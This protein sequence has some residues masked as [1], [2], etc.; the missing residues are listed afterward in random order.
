MSISAVA[1]PSASTAGSQ[2]EPS[3]RAM[4]WRST[5]VSSASRGGRLGGALVGRGGG[6]GVGH[7]GNSR[8]TGAGARRGAQRP[9]ERQARRRRARDVVLGGAGRV[10]R[11]GEDAEVGRRGQAPLVGVEDVGPHDQ[12]AGHRLHPHLGL[13]VEAGVGGLPAV[14]QALVLGRDVVDGHED[15]LERV[16]DDRRQGAVPAVLLAAERQ[17][18][19][20]QPAGGVEDRVRAALAHAGG[21]EVRPVGGV[22]RHGRQG[23]RAATLGVLPCARTTRL[24][25]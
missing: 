5:P 19:A 4:S 9:V 10:G 7:A 23:Y 20:G 22:Q 18:P 16:L 14:E 17:P 25:A 1:S 6:G 8:P 15:L 13:A 2:P 12:L 3:T 24:G 11:V 21:I